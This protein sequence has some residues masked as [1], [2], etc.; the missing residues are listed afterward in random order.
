MVENN[1]IRIRGASYNCCVENFN[2]GEKESKTKS[3][4]EKE[5]RENTM[6]KN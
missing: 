3:K 5:D 6:E 4:T 2:R 1:V